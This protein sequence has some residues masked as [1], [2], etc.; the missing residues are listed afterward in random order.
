MENNFKYYQST[1]P[2]IFLVVVFLLPLKASSEAYHGLEIQGEYSSGVV[3]TKSRPRILLNRE[4]NTNNFSTAKKIILNKIEQ[5][6]LHLIKN[7]TPDFASKKITKGSSY[8]YDALHASLLA[9]SMSNISY[10]DGKKE[11]KVK[12]KDVIRWMVS[13]AL[14]IDALDDEYFLYDD[15]RIR[16]TLQLLA[17]FYDW[18]FKNL[19]LEQDKIIKDIIFKKIKILLSYEYMKEPSLV[20]GHARW[21]MSVLVEAV[22]AIKGEMNDIEEEYLD[23]LIVKCDEYINQFN[24]LQKWIS[25]SGGTHLGWSYGGV[26]SLYDITNVWQS[27]TNTAIVDDWQEKTYLWYLYGMLSDGTYFNQGDAYSNEAQLGFFAAIEAVSYG[28]GVAGWFLNKKINNKKYNGG[29]TII[30]NDVSDGKRWAYLKLFMHWNENIIENTPDNMPLV[31]FFDPAGGLIIRDGWADD[32]TVF[33]LASNK[34]YSFNHNHHDEGSINLHYKSTLLDESGYYDRYGSNHFKNYYIRSVAHNVPLITN[35]G[36]YF[37]KGSMLQNISNDG[38]QVVRSEV[39]DI[40][41]ILKEKNRHDGIKIVHEEDELVYAKIDLT[42]SYLL[43][44][45]SEIT[46]EIFYIKRKSHYPPVIFV[47]DF[48]RTQE[49]TAVSNNFHVNELVEESDNDN[50]MLVSMGHDSKLKIL[51]ILPENA[52]INTVTGELLYRV[53][54]KYHPP[55][56]SKEWYRWEIEDKVRIEIEQSKKQNPIDFL[57]YFIP[58][59][60]KYPRSDALKK[61][62]NS[63]YVSVRTNDFVFIKMRLRNKEIDMKY[64]SEDVGEMLFLLSGLKVE[65][66]CSAKVDDKIISFKSNMYGL[67]R[68]VLNLSHNQEIFFRCNVL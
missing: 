67:A 22:I 46:R 48:I 15:N 53:D 43:N 34:F 1:K 41:D 58:E 54:G 32:S 28:N 60:K 38:G 3:V 24:Y 21:G 47:Y 29:K 64:I 30:P 63:D 49:I 8:Y 44:G 61:S 10:F 33:F 12:K 27:G 17:R 14:S 16:S 5:D 19:S 59:D 42:D 13:L 6:T 18:N 36:Y 68:V 2:T 23:T 55:I 40:K 50:K 66:E 4:I 45:E 39:N 51:S 57:T 37:Y 35:N 25:S 9:Y 26:E 52:D 65:A 62:I 56:L 7:V 20:G 31:H 11:N